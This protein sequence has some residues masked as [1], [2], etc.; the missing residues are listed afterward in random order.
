[1]EVKLL[2]HVNLRTPR[3][4]ELA[5]WYERILGVKQGYRPPFSVEG[6][7]LY[8]GDIPS[9]HL[10]Q[11]PEAAA[12]SGAD[13]PRMEHFCLRATGLEEFLKGL[14]DEGIEYR[15]LR[16]PELR[17]LQV[18]LSDPEGNHMHIDFPPQE[19]DELGL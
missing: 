5:R 1:M 6:I 2:E 10:L 15:T 3:M 4:E 12:P 14:Q 8:I 9:I 19:A 18:Y 11:V 16:V 17:I 7:W 13:S